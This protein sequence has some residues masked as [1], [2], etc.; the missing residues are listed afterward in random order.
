MNNL[1]FQLASALLCLTLFSLQP[2]AKRKI[3]VTYRQQKSK[4]GS[5]IAFF[6]IMTI[7]SIVLIIA[8]FITET[9]SQV[10]S[11]NPIWSIAF[12][13]I[14]IVAT[15]TYFIIKTVI[16]KT[17]DLTIL[18]DLNVIDYL[19]IIG[20]LF[21]SWSFFGTSFIEEEHMT[22]YFFW[23]TLMFFILVRTIVVIVMYFAKRWSGATEV[24]EK[25]DLE[26]RMSSVGVSIVPQW[27]LL[28]ALHRWVLHQNCL[29][30]WLNG[31]FI[32]TILLHS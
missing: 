16:E 30:C 26:N 20:T 12:I 21:H 19:L 7:S 3:S 31:F 2:E 22:W 9:K 32:K 24:Q 10:C 11:F 6:I 29:L 8:C 27:V 5:L 1:I 14:T 28:I 4:A 17:K 15:V 25:P 13:A 18:R 23:N